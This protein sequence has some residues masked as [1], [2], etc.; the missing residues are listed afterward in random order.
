MIAA[1]TDFW[2]GIGVL[3]LGSA[4]ALVGVPEGVVSPRNVRILVLSPAFW[5]TILAWV[6][7]FLGLV[8]A[9]QAWRGRSLPHEVEAATA[10][11]R[12]GLA[13]L[14]V[15]AAG[16]VVFCAFATTLGLVWSSMIAFGVVMLLIGMTHRVAAIVLAILLPLALYAFFAHV[17]LVPIPQGLFVRLP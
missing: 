3:A 10:P 9:L 12:P 1:R 11:S 2:T 7:A 15:L 16:S 8:L 13:R 4:L 14:A 6:M 17:A 5:P